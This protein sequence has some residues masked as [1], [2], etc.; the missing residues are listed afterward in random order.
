MAQGSGHNDLKPGDFPGIRAQ[1]PAVSVYTD[2]GV[3]SPSSP[4]RAV[5]ALG[6]WIPKPEVGSV[7]PADPPVLEAP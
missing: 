2:G 5:M 4:D 1:D 6:V 7:P 3:F